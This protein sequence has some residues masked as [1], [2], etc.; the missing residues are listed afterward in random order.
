MKTGPGFEPLITDE[1]AGGSHHH[2]RI[3]PVVKMRT[4]ADDKLGHAS[5]FEG[6]LL[7]EQRLFGV[8]VTGAGAGIE[9]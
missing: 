6:C 1:N 4:P 5:V 3:H 8:V 9:F 7:R 2:A